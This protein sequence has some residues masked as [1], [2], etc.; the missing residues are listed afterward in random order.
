MTSWLV[1]ATKPGLRKL[2]IVAS[3]NSATNVIWTILKLAF[4]P[5]TKRLPKVETDAFPPCAH[6]R[7][8]GGSTKP[9]TVKHG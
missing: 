5:V 2:G 3:I 1:I 7:I 6:K 9:P 4:E 8:G